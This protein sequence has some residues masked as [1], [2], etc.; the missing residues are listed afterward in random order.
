MT[1]HLTRRSFVTIS[2]V[3]AA[4][5]SI[6]FESL[7]NR[8]EAKVPES[9]FNNEMKKKKKRL[10][11]ETVEQFVRVAHFDFD[12]VKEM[13]EREPWLVNA[14]WDWGG[15]DFES[16]LGAASHRG[17]RYIALH[18]IDN[19][20]RPTLFTFAML[21]ELELVKAVLEVMPDTLHTPGPHGIPLIAHAY[22]GGE[23]SEAVVAYL[24]SKGAKLPEKRPSREM[25]RKRD[26]GLLEKYGRER[27]PEKLLKQHGRK[28]STI[29]A[30]D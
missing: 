17:E 19:G 3:S 28:L 21:G 24:E 14:V 15:G 2:A 29:E 30:D 23:K 5:G 6:V 1:K 7:R 27:E 4:T 10:N 20:A 8:C 13:L 16:A 18:L 12:K 22:F 11:P 26:Q 9:T 25:L